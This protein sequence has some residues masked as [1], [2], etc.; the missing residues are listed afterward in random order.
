MHRVG[1]SVRNDT[2]VKLYGV[3]EGVLPRLWQDALHY[4]NDEPYVGIVMKYEGGGSLETSLHGRQAPEMNMTEKVRILRGIALGL[5]EL[6]SLPN[7]RFVVHGDVKPANVLLGTQSPCT[8]KLADFGVSGFQ[9][10]PLL[11]SVD[12]SVMQSTQTARGT[13]RYSAPE[14]LRNPADL[15]VAISKQ[16]RTSDMYAF[17]MLSWEVLSGTRPFQEVI[18]EV[19]LAVLVHTGV[20]PDLATLPTHTPPNVMEMVKRCFGAD[21]SQRMNA[22]ECFLLL[23]HA[24]LSLSSDH[25]DIFFSHPWRDKSFLKHVFSMLTAAGYRVWYDQLE[26]NWSLDKS[27]EEGVNH[28]SVVLACVNSSYQS[29]LNCMKEL[30]MA[31][32]IDNPPK[33]IVCLVTEKEPFLW[34]SQDLKTLCSLETKLF[35]DIGE[36]AAKYEE[37]EWETP[38]EEMLSELR[39]SL[40]PLYRILSGLR[41]EKSLLLGV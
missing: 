10:S 41:V 36:V 18:D 16:S 17:G 27:M 38:T 30:E 15:N 2:V 25:F 14:M 26:M 39:L 22:N 29:R 37:V 19:E 8:V 3:V 31:A 12:M 23:E 7:G 20:R 40:K 4:R 34:A 28:S 9:E 32:V 5:S 13:P 21:R 35:C 6:H 24:Y 33:P 11:N 1:L